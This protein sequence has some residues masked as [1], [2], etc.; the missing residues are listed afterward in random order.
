[1][2]DRALKKHGGARE[3]AGRP[4]GTTKPDKRESIT[5]RLPPDLTDWLEVFGRGKGRVV[6]QALREF[7]E[8]N[9]GAK[10]IIGVTSDAYQQA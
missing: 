9:P 5:I 6:E 7:Q 10:R 2:R 1:M 3:G 8:R 4:E